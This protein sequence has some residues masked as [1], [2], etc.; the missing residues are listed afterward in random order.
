M[1]AAGA[2]S[3]AGGGT[4]SRTKSS[5]HVEKQA[6]LEQA[7]SEELVPCPNTVAD[8]DR[9][10]SREDGA[11][12]AFFYMVNVFAV[13]FG[14]HWVFGFAAFDSAFDAY[15]AGDSLLVLAD[16]ALAATGAVLAPLR[17][18][19]VRQMIRSRGPD[20]PLVRLG[21]GSSEPRISKSDLE[22]LT[23]AKKLQHPQFDQFTR[24][25]MWPYTGGFLLGCGF[26]IA[27]GYGVHEQWHNRVSWLLIFLW[28]TVVLVTMETDKIAIFNCMTLVRARVRA[29]STAVK[30]E[31]QSDG[32]D[33]TVEEWTTDV[34]RPC[35]QLIE[36]MDIL[37]Q[38]FVR[39]PTRHA[40]SSSS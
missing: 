5:W 28:A 3:A 39:R 25:Y 34:A 13:A 7:T 16:L 26:L 18:A 24:A 40:T 6:Q 30:R 37:T 12:T 21:A 2:S 23:H 29:I 15:E 19:E 33:M 20:G 9:W 32:V 1:G 31:M 35:R 4:L 17:L 27:A 36:E 11:P 38:A 10:L 8:V 22:T 14:V